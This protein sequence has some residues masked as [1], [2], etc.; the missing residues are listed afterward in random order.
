MEFEDAKNHLHEWGDVKEYKTK[1]LRTLAA[2]YLE[3]VLHI[4][5]FSEEK[6]KDGLR[7]RVHKDNP[8]EHPLASKDRG[9]Y[10]VDCVTDLSSYE[11]SDIAKM[12]MNVNDHSINSFIQLVRRRI[13]SLERPLTTARGDKKSYIYANLNPEYAQ[14]MVTI[15]RTYYNFCK[16]MKMGS[17]KLTPAQ[18]LG[19][20]DKQFSF[21]DILYFK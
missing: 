19:I 2:H 9:S 1:N 20:V 21:E 12:I 3:E 11:P 13:S 4:H 6:V 7:Y 10:T 18:R 14:Y 17:K 15:L 8:I 5:E 16:P